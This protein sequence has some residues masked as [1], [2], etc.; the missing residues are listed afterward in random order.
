M[1]TLMINGII[2]RK[3]MQ[4]QVEL[5][6]NKTHIIDAVAPGSIAEELNIEAGDELLSIN[7]QAVEDIFDYQF[8]TEDEYLEVLIK[9]ADGE[10][11]ELE[12][13]KDEDEDLGLIFN[14]GLMDDYRSCSNK[15]IFCFIDQMPRGMRPTLYF[16]DDDS[17]LSFMQGNYITLTNLSDHDLERIMTYRLELVNISFHTTEPELRGK[18]LGNRFAGEALKKARRL[19]EAG[20]SMNGQIVL[21]KGI[22]D[23][24]H[25]R[26]SIEDLSG[27]IPC[28]QSV[29][30]VP[31]GLS[32]FREGLFPLEGFTREDAAQVLDMIHSY[33]DRFYAEYK[34]HFIHAADEF[35]LLANRE[36]PD[37]DSY[38]GYLQYENGVGMIR[39][40]VDEFDEALNEL[41]SS[42]YLEAGKSLRPRRISLAGGLLMTPF[43]NE[44][45]S[46]LTELIPSLEAAY[47]PIR[48]DFFGEK[49]TVSGLL[50]GR[51]II[52]QLKGKPLGEALYLPENL[53]RAGESV[54][55]DDTTVEDIAESLQVKIHIVKSDGYD[56][57]HKIATGEED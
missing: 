19:Y 48:N 21:C 45:L 41:K 52:S 33:Q 22:N 30:V 42:K 27:F 57:V 3:S 16:K 9:K 26:R 24:E 50:T 17:R 37:A 53:L 36:L 25:L 6:K 28:L 32:R 49:I 56:F 1:K 12:I 8:L 29:S 7:G 15:C 11:W 14:N 44:M 34:T 18:M 4:G 55:L 46:K 5:T 13:D 39:S 43:I 40:F 38:D 35:Y 2:L 47:Y 10:E 31:V 54:L 51:D 20:I 23:G